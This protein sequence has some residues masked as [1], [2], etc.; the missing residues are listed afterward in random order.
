MRVARPWLAA[1]LVVGAEQ[2]SGTA[3]QMFGAGDVM[4]GVH[5][6]A[7]PATRQKA[8]AWHLLRKTLALVDPTPAQAGPDCSLVLHPRM[9]SGP[10]SCTP[11]AFSPALDQSV[12]HLALPMMIWRP[13]CFVMEYP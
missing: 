2:R 10:T 1:G 11:G 3:E 13:E 4:G 8:L 5:G 9:L 6:D 12:V 7:G